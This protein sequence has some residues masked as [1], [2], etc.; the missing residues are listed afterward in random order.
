MQRSM[1]P[2]ESHMLNYTLWNYTSDNINERG[3]RWNDEDLSIFSREQQ[4][5][6]SDINSGGRAL[7]AVVRPYPISTVGQPV[8]LSFN[9]H[10][11]DFEFVFRGNNSTR[12]PTEIFV[13][14]FQYPSG[15][16]VRVSDGEFQYD[17]QVQM[18]T[19]QPGDLETHT[20]RI[21]RAE[22]VF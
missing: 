3:D 14:L 18:L 16:D 8:S 21:R 11:G 6:P 10:S 20:I 7:Q 9:I 1:L 22:S 17:P 2:L 12:Q 5:D 19:Y 13:P 15:I 4:T